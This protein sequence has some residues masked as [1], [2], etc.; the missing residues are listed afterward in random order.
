MRFKI[1][2]NTFFQIAGKLVSSGFGFLTT[3]LI[4]RFYSVS[5]FG[6][7]IKIISFGTA[8][9]IMGDFGLN[10]IAIRE[11]HEGGSV[12][13]KFNR[14]LTLRVIISL[15][16]MFVCVSLLAFLPAGYGP[17][18]KLG[19]IIFSF[20]ILSQN[21][22]LTANSV[23]QQNL[24][25]QK[26]LYALIIT[27]LTSFVIIALAVWQRW[28]ILAVIFSF[29]LAGIVLIIA[30]L[31]FVKQY[32]GQIV[33]R[34]DWQEMRKMMFKAA[35]LGLVLIFNVIYFHIDSFLLASMKT[36]RE[37]GL[38]G[39]AYKFFETALVVPTFYG[40][41]VYPVLLTRLKNDQMGFHRLFRKSL[42]FL[43]A[44]SVLMTVVFLPIAPLFI[45]LATNSA[46]YAGAVTALQI[47]SFSFPVF[48]L[49]AIFM[50]FF[51]ALNKKTL[52]LVVYGSSL[53]VNLVLN[54][55]FIP[56]FGYY[57]AAAI[58]GVSEV[59]ILVIFIFYYKFFPTRFQL[60]DE[61]LAAE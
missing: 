46:A 20:T 13:D 3:I 12:T 5:D 35:P 58:T 31:F 4:A 52:L 6:E 29:S 55:I 27:N 45:R 61:V 10:A 44:G 16:L 48:F 1:L 49:S 28:P 21:I 14:L 37:V 17:I 2:L 41:S 47:L 24:A 7:Y 51:V 9:W 34:F 33:L 54:L 59:Y 26:T 42:L 39:L 11:Y 36:S 30:S 60:K 43:A 32:V 50:W 15:V 38:Y 8:F 56:R 53:V 40:N 19:I 57:A 25:Y 18:A 22:H 23:F